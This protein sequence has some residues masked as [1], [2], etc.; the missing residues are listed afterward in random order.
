MLGLVGGKSKLSFYCRGLFLWSSGNYLILSVKPWKAKIAE[1]KRRECLELDLEIARSQIHTLHQGQHTTLR[2]LRLIK[3]LKSCSNKVKTLRSQLNVFHN[4]DYSSITE[5]EYLKNLTVCCNE[6]EALSIGAVKLENLQNLEFAT[7]QLKNDKLVCER[8]IKQLKALSNQIALEAEETA[9]LIASEIKLAAKEEAE[10]IIANTRTSLQNTVYGP[11]EAAHQELLRRLEGQRKDCLAEVERLQAI[12]NQVDAEISQKIE[13]T[14][15][16]IAEKK[17]LAGEEYKRIKKEL[18]EKAQQQFQAE[19]NKMQDVLEQLN[20][21][22]TH[23]ESENQMLR[24][25]LQQLDMPLLPEGWGFDEAY[26]RGIIDFYKE[27]TIKLDYK[28]SWKENDRLV[29]RLIPRDRT[30]GEQQLRSYSDRLQRQ[31]HLT[32]LPDIA[33]I[34]GTIQFT[35]KIVELQSITP[36]PILSSSPYSPSTNTQQLIVPEIVHPEMSSSDAREFLIKR[37]YQSFQPPTSRFNPKEPLTQTERDW[38]LWLWNYCKIQDQNTI[39]R[40]VWKNSRGSGIKPGAGSIY[41]AA[42]ERLHQVLEEAGIRR[43]GDAE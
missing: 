36:R 7:E 30:V 32:E 17:K 16:A 2:E 1:A 19:L 9:E 25:E 22:I 42:R 24:H 12:S 38:V 37:E 11:T 18:Q 13:T 20:N 15:R 3:K 10:E 26:A 29:I 39:M 31:F 28:K 4:G 21:Q 41:I 23:L 27:K 34:E 35:L 5:H 33:T 6:R 14:E 8:E 40:T 43:S